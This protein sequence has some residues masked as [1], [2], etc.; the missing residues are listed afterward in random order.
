MKNTFNTPSRSSNSF[1]GFAVGVLVTGLL[2]G[3]YEVSQSELVAE[4]IHTAASVQ[5]SQPEPVKLDTVVVTAKRL[6][7]A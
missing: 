3:G 1:A 6:Q 7:K 2:F 5:S 4:A